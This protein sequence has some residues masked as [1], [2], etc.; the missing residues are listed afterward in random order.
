MDLQKLAINT[1]L[2][3][4]RCF[5]INL[6]REE[7]LVFGIIYTNLNKLNQKEPIRKERS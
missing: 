1:I 2:M 6:Y 4:V 5:R 3:S 7:A